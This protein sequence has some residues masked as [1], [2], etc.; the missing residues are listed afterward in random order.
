MSIGRTIRIYLDD[1]SISGVRHAEIV[2]WTGQAISAPRT[3]VKSL[4]EWEESKKPGVYFLFGVDEYSGSS[5]V[6]IGEAENVLDRLQSHVV[7]KDFWNEVVLFTSKDENLTKSH[8]KYLESRLV[9]FAKSANR[10]SVL[11][12]NEPQQPL[13]PRGDR[14]AMEEFLSN[15]RVLLGVIGHKT[16]E[17]LAKHEVPKP[18]TTEIDEVSD[19]TLIESNFSLNVKNITAKAQ[20]TDEG[21]VVLSGSM[22]AGDIC[23]SLSTGYKKLRSQLIESGIINKRSDGVLVFTKDQLFTSPSQAAAI[24]VG[25]AI[26]GRNSWQTESGK[27]LKIVEEQVATSI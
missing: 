8:V 18:E 20:L 17:S 24:I 13:L 16:L 22:V 4:S 6:Y 27:T 1:G 5:A 23:D 21:I 2:N 12:G 26:N 14:D 19:N 10:Y 7:N 3:Q 15:I 25:Y 9:Q 11:N